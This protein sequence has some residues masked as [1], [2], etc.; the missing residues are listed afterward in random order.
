MCLNFF[1]YIFCDNHLK[2]INLKV[3]C[4]T[5]IFLFLFFFKKKIILLINIDENTNLLNTYKFDNIMVTK[6][7]KIYCLY[8]IEYVLFI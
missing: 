8:L 5:T 2:C 4:K 7:L 6:I 3:I 1:L